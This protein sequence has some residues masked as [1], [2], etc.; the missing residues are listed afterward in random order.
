VNSGVIARPRA[1]PDVRLPGDTRVVPRRIVAHVLD[2]LVIGALTVGVSPEASSFWLVVWLLANWI[3]LQGLTG[4]SVGKF[5]TRIRVVDGRGG[6]PGLGRA[7]IRT[8]PLVI[9]QLGVIA[10]WAMLRRPSRQRFG[11]RW[12]KTFVVKDPTRWFW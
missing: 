7:L 9:E 5:V 4:Y 2:W 3:V 12:A 1:V 6:V 11:D 8:L 10:I